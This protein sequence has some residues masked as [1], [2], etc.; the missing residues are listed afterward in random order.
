MSGAVV[1]G[2]WSGQASPAD[3]TGKGNGRFARPSREDPA[4]GGYS[5]LCVLGHEGVD[6]LRQVFALLGQFGGRLE[7]LVRGLSLVSVICGISRARPAMLGRR[8]WSPK[9]S[10]PYPAV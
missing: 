5:D 1:P 8:N 4:F 9:T 6:L 3:E 10:P 2:G 7:H